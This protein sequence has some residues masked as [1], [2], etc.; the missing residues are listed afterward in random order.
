MFPDEAFTAAFQTLPKALHGA[1]GAAGAMETKGLIVRLSEALQTASQRLGGGVGGGTPLSGA[2]G[3]GGKPSWS[4]KIM[5]FQFDILNPN[6]IEAVRRQAASLVVEIGKQTKDAIREEVRLGMLWGENPRE[7]ARA[8]RQG[9][10][11]TAKQQQAVANFRHELMTFHERTSDGG[12]NLGG[13]ISRA[14]GGAQTFA[15]DA[16][17]QPKDAIFERRLRDFRYDR[18]LR[19]AMAS[20]KPL[21]PAQIDAM[22]EAY[23]RKYLKY[24]SET[25][26]TTEALRASNLAIEETWRQAAEQRL[27]DPAN[28]RKRWGLALGSDRT[29]LVCRPMPTINA[30]V[31]GEGLPMDA[32]FKT[33]RGDQ[34][35]I[36]PIHPRCRC[37][38][39]VRA[40]S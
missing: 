25:I 11:L 13:K 19:A 31:D 14:P 26:A 15:V 36:P 10:G 37:V 12:W 1:A 21:T 33:T 23:R 32:L 30:G 20:G 38:L 9:I 18:T 6:V 7:T 16:Q 8:I 29:C 2:V 34:V 5:Q 3:L 39:V 28:L 35:R 4:P 22:T 27:V 24:R 40:V 17:G